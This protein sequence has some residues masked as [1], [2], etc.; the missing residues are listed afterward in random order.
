VS[1]PVL[2]LERR[3]G[4]I[5]H[6]SLNRP[7]VRN[8]FNAELIAALRDTFL[9]L[10]ADEFVRTIVLR[11]AGA[12]FCGGA[13]IG[14]MR[15][16]LALSTDDNVRDAERMADMFRAI[17]RCSKPVIGRICGAALGGGAGL[18]AA[19]DVV[20]AS[21]ETMFGFTETKLGLVPAVI[22]PFVLAKIGR[23]AA[24][25]LFLTGE[26]FDAERAQRIGLAH[27]IVALDELDARVEALEIEFATAGP[28]AVAAAKRL[29]A[30]VSECHAE[31]TRSLTARA[32][33]ARRTSPEGQEGLRAFLERRPPN[34][35]AK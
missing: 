15:D 1:E 17:D 11:G 2:R 7:A 29:I 31:Q 27:Y 5:A 32:I 24:R 9:A 4:G 13:D 6:V 25:A 3:G 20:V 8:A 28:A 30:E 19:C 10:D 14:W 35:V 22:S 16:A 21:A 12:V 18:A 26:R 34:W 23:S 33:A